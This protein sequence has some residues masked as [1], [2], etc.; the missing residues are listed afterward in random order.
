MRF[1]FGCLV[2]TM[3]WSANPQHD[4]GE[5]ISVHVKEVHREAEAE[6]TEKGSWFH[7]TAVVETKAIIYSLKCDEFYSYK[8]S[9]YAV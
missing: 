8:K 3:P 9:D 2:L 6:P 1:L 4:K 7:I 5:S